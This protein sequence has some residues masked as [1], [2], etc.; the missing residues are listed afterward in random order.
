MGRTW[1]RQEIQAVIVALPDLHVG[2]MLTAYETSDWQW[3]RLVSGIDGAVERIY[4]WKDCSNEEKRALNELLWSAQICMR[5]KRVKDG[6]PW[7]LASI[8]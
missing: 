7:A 8:D 1:A 2:W 6:N 3:C 4:A 5:Y